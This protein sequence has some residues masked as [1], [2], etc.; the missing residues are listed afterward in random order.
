MAYSDRI[1]RFDTLIQTEAVTAN[2]Q[3]TAVTV[4]ARKMVAISVDG[5]IYI[6]FGATTTITA[7]AAD[8]LLPAA[9]IYVMQMPAGKPCLRLFAPAGGSTINTSVISLANS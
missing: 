9:G 8:Y 7:S 6:D 4:G 5:P 3:G 1:L 2:A